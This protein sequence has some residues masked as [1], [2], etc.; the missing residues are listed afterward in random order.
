MRQDGFLN[1]ISKGGHIMGDLTFKFLIYKVELNPWT[2]V[3]VL[4]F[5]AEY[6]FLKFKASKK[7]LSKNRRHTIRI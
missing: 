4:T 5:L 6:S 3:T 1:A 2:K 7:I